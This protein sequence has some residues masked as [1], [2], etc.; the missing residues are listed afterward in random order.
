VLALSFSS[1]RW[2]LAVFWRHFKVRNQYLKKVVFIT[3]VS[4]FS[5]CLLLTNTLILGPS[6]PPTSSGRTRSP[7]GPS[8]NSWA[9]QRQP[10]WGLR[11]TTQ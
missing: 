4:T 5:P 8:W 3:W 11:W 1:N 6:G 2:Y 7:R 10:C 9:C